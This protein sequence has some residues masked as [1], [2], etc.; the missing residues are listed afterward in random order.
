[1]NL[2]V[3]YG[4]PYSVDIIRRKIPLPLPVML[5]DSFSSTVFNGIPDLHS[6]MCGNKMPTRCNRWFLLQVLLL[7]QYVSG[8]H[9]AHHQELESI[10]QVVAACGIWC[11]GFKVVS[12]VWSWGSA[13]HHIDNLKT[14]AP[15][16]TGS[17]HLYDTLELLMMGIVVTEACWASNKICN[18]THLLHLVGILFPH[19]NDDALSKSH[20]IYIY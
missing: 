13:P 16:T 1:M 2:K 20:Q 7:A 12:M 18:K 11:F 6:L 5:R 4:V 19:F 3:N 14:K 10:V 8:H 15:N 17:N 9:Y